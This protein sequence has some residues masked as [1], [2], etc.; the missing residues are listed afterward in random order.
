MRIETALMCQETKGRE[1]GE[2]RA[3]RIEKALMCQET[4][5][6]ERGEKQGGEKKSPHLSL[7]RLR[8]DG[9]YLQE[10]HNHNHPI[11]TY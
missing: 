5:G 7:V 2:R 1:R 8:L 3:V 9:M 10:A 4:K 6:R 11:T